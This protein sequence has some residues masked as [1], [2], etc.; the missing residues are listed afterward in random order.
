MTP[1]ELRKKLGFEHTALKEMLDLI[2]FIQQQPLLQIQGKNR[3]RMV[4][5]KPKKPSKKVADSQGKAL[6]S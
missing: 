4:S 6:K 5:L 2:Q 3:I 1:T